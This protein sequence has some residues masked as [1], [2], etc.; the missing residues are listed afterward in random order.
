MGSELL[1]T[2]AGEGDEAAIRETNEAVRESAQ[3]LS[4][5]R[6]SLIEQTRI[7]EGKP[8]PVSLQ[9]EPLRPIVEAGARFQNSRLTAKRTVSLE[10]N[11]LE[12]H[13]DRSK[14]VTVFM[15][16][17]GNALK[18]SSGEVRV[19][20]CKEKDTVL[21][22]VLDQGTAG[23]GISQAQAQ[24]LFTPFGRLETHAAVEGT[25][26]GLASARKIVEAHGGEVF[27]EG[28]VDGSPA[29]RPFSTAQGHYSSLLIPG[30][31]TGFVIACPVPPTA[32]DHRR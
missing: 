26:L 29:S 8:I 9:A 12:V 27:I 19:A 15:N 5:L 20:W 25:G 18:Y 6:L 28:H 2:I 23:Q 11:A 17:I 10:G 22:G 21:V 32:T 31:P 4:A 30:F 13:A 16:L 7:L 3:M 14:L 24:R 1:D